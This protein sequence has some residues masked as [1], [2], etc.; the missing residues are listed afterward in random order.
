MEMRMQQFDDEVPAGA[1]ALAGEDDNFQPLHFAYKISEARDIPA[2][3]LIRNATF[4]SHDQL[5]AL[6]VEKKLESSRRAFNWR[7][8]RYLKC[9]YVRTIG[10]VLPY[11]GEVYTITRL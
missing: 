4:I 1:T 2:L 9:E 8:K 10:R 11:P 6:L 3:L 5:F 7:V